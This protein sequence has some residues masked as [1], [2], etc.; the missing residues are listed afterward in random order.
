MGTKERLDKLVTQRRLIRSRSRAQRMI[1]AGRV[2]VDGHTVYRPGHMV[3]PEAAI[4]IVAPA[5]Y[6]SR[7]GEKLEG[8][9]ADF[10]V[11]PK[12]RNCL[13]IGSDLAARVLRLLGRERP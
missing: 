10:R 8:A 11:D 5:P 1:M 13:D 3:D 7:G 4:E 9:L 6:V 12:A 2:R